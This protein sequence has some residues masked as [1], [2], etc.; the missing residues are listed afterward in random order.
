MIQLLIVAM[1]VGLVA[2]R[3]DPR[4]GTA[5]TAWVEAADRLSDDQP[6]SACVSSRLTSVTSLT[7]AE[8]RDTADVVLTI[9]G[10]SIGKHPLTKIAG[11]LP[12]GSVLWQGGS[13]TRGFN[14]VGRD[15]TCVLADDVLTNLRDDMRRARDQR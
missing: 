7:A 14:L 1:M 11:S 15:M 13:K 2:D 8:R 12:D 3:L 6:V 9:S 10:T 5:H 4:L